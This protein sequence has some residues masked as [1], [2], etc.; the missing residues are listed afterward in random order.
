[1]QITYKINK[2]QTNLILLR[3]PFVPD[4]FVLPILWQMNKTHADIVSYYLVIPVLVK[5]PWYHNSWHRNIFIRTML[6]W[7][8]N[9]LFHVYSNPHSTIITIYIL[10]PLSYTLYTRKTVGN[11]TLISCVVFFWFFADNEFGEKTV[12]ILLDDDEASIIFIDHP[13]SEMSVSTMNCPK[14]LNGI[15]MPA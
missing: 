11:F 9:T 13:F 3:F 4:S 15:F 8:S 2:I 6:V 5:R 12:S 1:M 10:H 14:A 7:V